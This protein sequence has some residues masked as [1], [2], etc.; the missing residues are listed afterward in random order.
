MGV[1]WFCGEGAGL[2]DTLYAR[3][4]SPWSLSVAAVALCGGSAAANGDE[5]VRRRQEYASAALRQLVLPRDK[6]TE[7]KVGV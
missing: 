7:G 6:V 2:L 1:A 4:R 5:V 3:C